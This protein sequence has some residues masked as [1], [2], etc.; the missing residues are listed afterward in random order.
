MQR[1]NETLPSRHGNGH[2]HHVAQG[3]NE[4]LEFAA[5]NNGVLTR[6]QA[7][8]LGMSSRTIDRRVAQGRLVRVTSQMVLLP[9]TLLSEKAILA[10][11]T[12][13]LPAVVSHQSAARMH[14]VELKWPAGQSVSVPVRRSN[15]FLGVTVHQL[16]DLLEQ[17]VT[18]REGLPIT[19]A[20][21][22]VVDLA[23][24]VASKELA[25]V[26]DHLQ[27]RGQTSYEEV[28]SLLESLARKGK[29]GVSRLRKL[30]SARLGRPLITESAL[31]TLLLEVIVG[32]GLPLPTT[33]FHP[34]WLRRIKGRVD[35]A[36]LNENLIIEADSLRWHGSASSFQL[37]R[38]RDNLAQLAG[39]I[40]LRFTWE[41]LTTR[42][43]Y[44]VGSLRRALSMRSER[45]M[46]RS[47]H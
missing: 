43:S 35:M 47:E 32:G 14:G 4:A 40:V 39:W 21:R 10:A 1:G 38:Q 41:D 26:L 18:R 33:Q 29:P 34:T 6:S 30:L 8:A 15:R 12:T 22:T 42:P 16:T 23:A 7:M 45:H 13:A 31:E 25:V 44:V 37:D 3:E 46:W 9:G 11:A 28:A 36:Y 2:P 27:R 20:T 17:H 19:T 24:V 5:S